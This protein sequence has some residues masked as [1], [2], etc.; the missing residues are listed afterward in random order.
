MTEF[1]KLVDILIFLNSRILWEKNE[2]YKNWIF[3]L[4]IS[5]YYTTDAPVNASQRSLC[6]RDL[7][8]GAVL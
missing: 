3:F 8:S 6:V 4:P 7:K 5:Q 2:I 1:V